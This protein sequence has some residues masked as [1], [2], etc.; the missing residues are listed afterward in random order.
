METLKALKEEHAM[1][2]K[3]DK[4]T[5]ATMENILSNYEICPARY[6]GLIAR[7]LCQ[8]QRRYSGKYKP[9]CSLL[10]TQFTHH[11]AQMKI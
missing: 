9:C 7:S 8:R 2:T 10:S 6:H 5:T 4:S 11:D 3:L 1:K